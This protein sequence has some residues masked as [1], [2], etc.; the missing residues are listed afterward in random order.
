M[1]RSLLYLL[2]KK[3][4]DSKNQKNVFRSS[5]NSLDKKEKNKLLEEVYN[6]RK[7]IYKMK[8]EN[9]IKKFDSNQTFNPLNKINS[10][11]NENN[12]INPV[13][14]SPS[15]SFPN[16]FENRYQTMK[17]KYLVMATPSNPKK[18]YPLFFR[19]KYFMD[20]VDG[21]CP[22]R[23]ILE[24]TMKYERNIYDLKNSGF[25]S[26]TNKFN[27]SYTNKFQFKEKND[28][29]V[30]KRDNRYLFYDY[31]FMINT[32]NDKLNGSITDK[33]FRESFHSLRKSNSDYGFK[34]EIRDTN[35][36]QRVSQLYSDIN[37]NIDSIVP[38][39]YQLRKTYSERNPFL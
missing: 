33:Y 8:L 9:E 37:T 6:N 1:M 5:I 27:Q 39:E 28:L 32:I 13:P 15:I 25:N 16:N 20:Y 3:T 12:Q 11:S 10:F 38:Q 31:G 29:S 18:Q 26:Y 17:N 36:N 23:E 30:E 14:I 35:R 4:D 2:D 24:R 22:N 21:R 7:K 34:R 19:D